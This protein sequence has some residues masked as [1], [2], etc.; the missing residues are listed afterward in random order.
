MYIYIYIHR[1]RDRKRYPPPCLWKAWH[2]I[3]TAGA[4]IPVWNPSTAVPEF[5]LG[6]HSPAGN[7]CGGP[8]EPVRE[9]DIFG[10]TLTESELFQWS[11]YLGNP[12]NATRLKRNPLF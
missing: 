11:R 8:A 6:L 2:V 10:K 9:S 4:G 12:E 7:P 5:L 1:E 3:L